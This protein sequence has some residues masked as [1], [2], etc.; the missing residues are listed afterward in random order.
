MKKRA[1]SYFIAPLFCIFFG[2]ATPETHLVITEYRTFAIAPLSTKGSPTDPASAS[3]MNEEVQAAISDTLKTKGYKPTP[4]SEADFVVSV[5]T[6]FS[7]DPLVEDSERRNLM[8][9]FYDRFNHNLVWSNQ[10]GRSSSRTMQPELLRENLLKMLEPV[11]KA[12]F[13]K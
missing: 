3:R 4:L 7:P 6:S 2:C 11:P 12:P 9:G 5:E 10:R 13:Q 8:I 1:L